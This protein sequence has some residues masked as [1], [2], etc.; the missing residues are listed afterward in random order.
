[1]LDRELIA[2]RGVFRKRLM[3][4]LVERRT[5]RSARRIVATS[6]LEAEQIRRLGFATAPI[7]ELPNGVDLEEWE[8]PPE[9]ALQAEVR[10]EL[11]RG[12]FVLFLG[13]LDR[14]KGLEDLLEA[15]AKLKRIRLVVAGPDEGGLGTELDRKAR[16]LELGERYQ[17][18][19]LV[20]GADRVALLRAASLLVLPSVSENFGNVVVEAMAC[21]VPVLTTSGVGA[22]V[23]VQDSGAGWVIPPASA[24][25]L[26]EALE[27]AFALPA[28]ELQ[29][30]GERGRRYVAGQLTWDQVAARALALYQV[31]QREEIR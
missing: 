30:R 20:L 29:R 22:A 27:R 5:F 23:H 2:A 24:Q 26:S 15:M 9:E 18:L 19:N 10:R 25:A 31:V 8:P 6:A 13:R 17:R 12:R 4:A 16:E 7:V 11:G 21:G 28:E 1:M 14:K 3:L